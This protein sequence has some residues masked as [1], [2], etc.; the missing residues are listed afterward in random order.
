MKTPNPAPPESIAD[1]PRLTVAPP[2]LKGLIVAD[3]T[4]GRVLGEEGSFHYRQFDA[5]DLARSRSFESVAALLIDGELPDRDG[6]ASFRA[7]LANARHLEPGIAK[8]LTPIAAQT[9]DLLAALRAALPLLVDPTP[10]IDLSAAERRAA[11]IRIAGAVPTIVAAVHRIQTGQGPVSADPGL[12]HAADYVRMV[13][14]ITP[15]PQIVEAIERYLLLTLDHGFNASTF[16]TRVI[17]STGADVASAL[18]GAVGALSGPLHGGAPSRV[19]D[20]LTDIGDPTNTERWAHRQLDAGNKIMGFGHAVYRAAD[21][22]T[23]LLRETA[24]SLGGEV[25]DQAIEIEGRML[26]VLA[27]W[28]PGAT[29]VTN[30][31]YYAALVMHLSGFPQEMFTPTF[32]TSRVVGWCAHLLEQADAAKII[33]PSARYV[34]PPPAQPVPTL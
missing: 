26:E 29:I 4:I 27:R 17:T 15:S 31:E 28:K 6:E 30:V 32:T 24:V 20:M 7:E 5:T 19:L 2:G 1:A 10:T 9:G 18:G 21:P 3:T 22:R 16:T 23:N 13:T 14:G 33:R 34:G 11:T 8:L 25:V 12:G